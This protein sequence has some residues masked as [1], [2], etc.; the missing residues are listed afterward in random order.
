MLREDTKRQERIGLKKGNMNI[1]YN[2]IDVPLRIKK[3][4]TS[5]WLGQV[6]SKYKVSIESLSYNFCSDEYLLEVN[7]EHL[8][9]D[10]YT[11]IITFDLS[12]KKGCI[13]GDIYISLDRVRAN[14]KENKATMKDELSRVMAHGLL[15][16]IG[17]MDKTPKEIVAMRKA[18]SEC[19]DLQKT[20]FHVKH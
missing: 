20:L 14:A 19:L 11:D 3:K 2:N 17:F 9:H 1:E 4:D 7:R 18:E 6:A 10:Y 13:E 8:N 15:H 12:E 5:L 16:L